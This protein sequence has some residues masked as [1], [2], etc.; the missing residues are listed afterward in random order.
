MK[1]LNGEIGLT[2]WELDAFDKA[3][4]MIKT[5]I[6]EATAEALNHGFEKLLSCV[7]F[8]FTKDED[9]LTL[10]L[11]P[12]LSEFDGDWVF[13][14]CTLKEVFDESFELRGPT[15]DKVKNLAQAMRILADYIDSRAEEIPEE[16]EDWE[17]EP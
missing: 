4:D 12:G 11:S 6:A 10:T 1:A 5:I 3:Q 16:Y 2:E 17:S 8:R 14:S 15:R 7:V 9:P 13:Y